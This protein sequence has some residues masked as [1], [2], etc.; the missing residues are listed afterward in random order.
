[1]H[2]ANSLLSIM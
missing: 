1:M 2:S